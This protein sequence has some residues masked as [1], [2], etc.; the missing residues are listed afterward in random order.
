M[1]EAHRTHGPDPHAGVSRAVKAQWL[2]LGGV[3]VLALVAALLG[4]GG[5]RTATGAA[6][7]A[8]RVFR[9][10]MTRQLAEARSLARQAEGAP[11][12][13]SFARRVRHE[14]LRAL[15]AP[16]PREGPA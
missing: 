15:A 10:D 9:A 16:A 12:L 3:A 7:P 4:I 6:N 13:E 1:C 11:A 14:D 8:D 2:G 5:Q